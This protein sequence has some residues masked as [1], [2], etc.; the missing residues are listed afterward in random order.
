MVAKGVDEEFGTADIAAYG[1]YEKAPFYLVRYSP[2]INGTI[3]GLKISLDSEVLR[4]DGSK[5]DGLYAGGETCNGE[6]MYRLYPSGGASLLWGSV[7]G[8]LAGLAAAKYVQG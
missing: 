2:G 1:T 6:F 7:S 5:I 8:R 3:G 4:E